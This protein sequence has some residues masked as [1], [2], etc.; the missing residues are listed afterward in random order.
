MKKCVANIQKTRKKAVKNQFLY[1][2]SVIPTD[3]GN[4]EGIKL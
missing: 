1:D 3:F 4:K 2:N